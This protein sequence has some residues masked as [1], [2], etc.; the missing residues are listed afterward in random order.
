MSTHLADTNITVGCGER[1]EPHHL[2]T[3]MAMRF[4]LLT[5]S[6]EMEPR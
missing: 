5:T 1:S 3:D 4:A 6:Y 2:A